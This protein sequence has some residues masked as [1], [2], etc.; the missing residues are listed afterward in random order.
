MWLLGDS[1]SSLKDTATSETSSVADVTEELEA[2]IGP[3]GC[4]LQSQVPK[5]SKPEAWESINFFLI[6]TGLPD[7]K[8][9]QMKTMATMTKHD[10]IK[11]A[12]K[13]YVG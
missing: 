9:C 10:T 8:K 12:M 7:P 3:L 5:W 13:Q 1:P 2:M 11:T 4:Y 6:S